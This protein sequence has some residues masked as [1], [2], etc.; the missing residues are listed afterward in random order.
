MSQRLLLIEN[1]IGIISE[2]DN[3]HPVLRFDRLYEHN[4]SESNFEYVRD[5]VQGH[6][7]EYMFVL[8]V[9]CD[10]DYMRIR[11]IP[12]LAQFTKEH[13]GYYKY[14]HYNDDIGWYLWSLGF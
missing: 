10:I 9:E 1:E 8:E 2:Y 14:K 7:I 12:E 5:E 6:L 13:F 4:I 11:I 3:H